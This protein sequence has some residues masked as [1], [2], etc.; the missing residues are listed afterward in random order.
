M[1]AEHSRLAEDFPEIAQGDD[2][3]LTKANKEIEETVVRRLIVE[4]AKFAALTHVCNNFN[5]T[6]QVSVGV[7]CRD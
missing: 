4:E 2:A 3:I 5:R 1:L 7:P 6:A